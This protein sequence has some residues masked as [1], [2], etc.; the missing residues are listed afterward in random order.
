MKHE[1]K[2]QVRLPQDVHAWIV[3]FASRNDRSMN[4]QIIQIL[5]NM[6]REDALAKEEA[7]ADCDKYVRNHFKTSGDKA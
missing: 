7:K 1:A 3:N 6:M 2:V 4:G 5:R